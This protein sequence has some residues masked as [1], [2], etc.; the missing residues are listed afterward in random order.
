VGL[1][2]NKK[3]RLKQNRLLFYTGCSKKTRCASSSTP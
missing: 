1:G 3:A 2:K